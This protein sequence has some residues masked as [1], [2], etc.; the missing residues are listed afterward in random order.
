MDSNRIVDDLSSL[1]V[2][3]WADLIQLVNEKWGV[4]ASAAI[5]LAIAVGQRRVVVEEAKFTV[6]LTSAGNN[7]IAVIKE[8]RVLTG[9]GLK[10]AR[11]LVDAAPQVLEVGVDEEVAAQITKRVF[12]VGGSATYINSSAIDA[13]FRSVVAKR[14]G[15]IKQLTETEPGT[16]ETTSFS[17]FADDSFRESRFKSISSSV[18][19]DMMIE[20]LSG[21][22]RS[23]VETAVA[24][25][26]QDGVVEKATPLLCGTFPPNRFGAS[27]ESPTQL[28]MT[29]AQQ[30]EFRI[31]FSLQDNAVFVQDIF[32]TSQL[33]FF[34]S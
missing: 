1:T 29:Q 16:R 21:D 30:D 31:L 12:A 5:A 20:Q 24:S 19:A 34:Q 32:R 10:E 25:L 33:A 14:A 4:A 26:L 2:L 23:S 9:L 7:R 3:E 15:K 11:D 13:Y 22:E 6:V 27:T 28:F 17:K 18:E 8:V